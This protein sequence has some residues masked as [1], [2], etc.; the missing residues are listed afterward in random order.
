MARE[1]PTRRHMCPTRLCVVV[2]AEERTSTWRRVVGLLESGFCPKVD[3]GMVHLML[4]SSA[5]VEVVSRKVRLK[6]FPVA[7][8]CFD[9]GARFL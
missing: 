3:R 7:A 1:P 6:I 9:G 5:I 2:L 4:G 8:R